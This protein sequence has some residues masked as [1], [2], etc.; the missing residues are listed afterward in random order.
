V[1]S[2]ALVGTWRANSGSVEARSALPSCAR[3][4]AFQENKAATESRR[5][6]HLDVRTAPDLGEEDGGEDEREHAVPDNDPGQLLHAEPAAAHRHALSLLWPH[7]PSCR[8]AASTYTAFC[9]SGTTPRGLQ[10]RPRPRRHAGGRQTAR[11]WQ[12]AAHA[13]PGRRPARRC[14]RRAWRA[15][16]AAGRGARGKRACSRRAPGAGRRG[17][18]RGA[19]VCSAPL[20]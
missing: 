19:R 17:V 12:P 18:R 3:C 9:G 13:R 20:A 10:T 8:H 7:R 16:R 4:T 11:A 2:W 6:A 14:A 15:R 1:A 5:R